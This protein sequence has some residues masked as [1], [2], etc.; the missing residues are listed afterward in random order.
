MEALIRWHNPTLGEVSPSEF[1][2][3]VEQSG[4]IR[5]IGRFVLTEALTTAGAWQRRL[6][7]PLSVAV[8]LSPRQFRDADLVPWIGELVERARVAP[9]SLELE[10]TE[11]VLMTRREDVEKALSGLSEL[12][13]RLVMDDFGTGY[14]SLSY[15]RTFPFDV[16][17]IDRSFVRDMTTDPADRE[18][19]NA[20]IAM[21]HGLG[22]QVVAEGVETVEQL[23]LLRGQ[24][25]DFAQGYLFSRPVSA[26]AMERLLQP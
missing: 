8:N 23:E 2:P 22:L 1:I 15:L 11:G 3:V 24:G 9:G 26:E 21:G 10:I 18:L 14:S 5:P 19:V 4:L 17:K 7:R 16:V 12:G 13:V 25:C 20:A 6:G